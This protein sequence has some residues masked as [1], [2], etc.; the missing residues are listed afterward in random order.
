MARNGFEK[1]FN[2]LQIKDREKI[3]KQSQF[4]AREEQKIT[5]ESE[6]LFNHRLFSFD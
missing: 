2:K 3:V 1:P 5:E 4:A 6:F